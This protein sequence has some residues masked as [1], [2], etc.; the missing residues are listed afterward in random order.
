[1]PGL[2]SG[3]NC[4]SGAQTGTLPAQG[5]TGTTVHPQNTLDC[6]ELQS[7]PPPA[8]QGSLRS[9]PPPSD[10]SIEC[11]LSPDSASSNSAAAGR[12]S[13]G[14]RLASL[15]AHGGFPPDPSLGRWA[16]AG[17]HSGRLDLSWMGLQSWGEHPGPPLLLDILSG[18][19]E[20]GLLGP[21]LPAALGPPPCTPQLKPQLH[22]DQPSM[23]SA[24]T[25]TGAH[26]ST[27]PPARPVLSES[28]VPV[29]MELT[30]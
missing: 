5:L 27:R 11:Q 26:S 28:E 13:A 29:L 19:K 16:G 12:T 17:P 20:V 25:A 3:M 1:M 7:Q 22:R 4:P 30:L 14:G 6:L 15:P 2:A 23:R 10:Q 18:L 8:E 9:Q 21:L 24:G